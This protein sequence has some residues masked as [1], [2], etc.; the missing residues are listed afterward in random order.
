M[1]SEIDPVRF[2]ELSVFNLV[3]DAGQ[4]FATCR[5]VTIVA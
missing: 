3:L 2:P 4:N 1:T 5:C